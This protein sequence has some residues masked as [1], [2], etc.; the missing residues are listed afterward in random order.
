MSPPTFARLH[1]EADRRSVG[2]TTL[3]R[4]LIETGL[5]AL[6]DDRTVTVRLAD[7]HRAIDVAAAKQAAYKSSSHWLRSWQSIWSD[8]QPRS[9]CL[10][11]QR[12]RLMRRRLTGVWWSRP[13]PGPGRAGG[14]AL[15]IIVGRGVS[16]AGEPV[17]QSG[18]LVPFG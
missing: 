18:V 2:V 4:E 12:S 5:A 10:M 3:M 15:R 11:V 7:L 16:N 8:G 13:M 9:L 14:R 6:D 1:S 17:E